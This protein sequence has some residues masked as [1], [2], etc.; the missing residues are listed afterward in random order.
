MLQKLL[1][2][3][4]FLLPLA[5][6][7]AGP[8][9]RPVPGSG[10]AYLYFP[11]EAVGRVKLKIVKEYANMLQDRYSVYFKPK[12]GREELICGADEENCEK[13]VASGAG[14]LRIQGFYDTSNKLPISMAKFTGA[15]SVTGAE[16]K[17]NLKIGSTETVRITTGCN[18][19]EYSVVGALGRG[20]SNSRGAGA[21]CVGPT[22]DGSGYLIA[23]HKA[24][25][26]NL[27]AKTGSEKIGASSTR[28]GKGNS[29]ILL[30]KW[31]KNKFS[32]R[33][34]A[35][36]TC[37]RLSIAV[38][39]DRYVGWHVPSEQ[40][41]SQVLGGWEAAKQ[42]FVVP[43]DSAGYWTSTEVSSGRSSYSMN[44]Y[45]WSNNAKN[46]TSRGSSDPASV[47]CVYN[48]PL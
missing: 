16:C 28:D 41:L 8:D 31:D 38:G 35:A 10:A 19:S 42:S 33:E 7:Q 20:D 13:L 43:K 48:V 2:G 21:L 29:K 17:L 40:E 34:S 4:F 12:N 23:A 32:E 11:G 37:E 36:H 6:A 22:Q 14:K 5:A 9:I 3:S 39:E 25:R 46:L 24:V 45:R 30:E 26:G 47:I 18:A 44:V 27:R 15:C 1:I